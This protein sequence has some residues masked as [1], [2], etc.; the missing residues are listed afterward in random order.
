MNRASGRP[1]EIDFDSLPSVPPVAMRVVSLCVDPDV[2]LA[3][4]SAAVSLDP[5]LSARILRTA[6][7]A[8]FNWGAEVI[9][10]D[11]AM[12]LMGIKLV[13]LTALGL[14]ISSSL[15][16]L[17]KDDEIVGQV[18]HQCLV[19]AV[20][21]RELAQLARLPTAPESWLFG[22]FDGMGHLLAMATNGT[23]FR[24]LLRLDPFP[25]VPAQRAVLG[26]STNELV[27]TA[28]RAWGV[29]ELYARVL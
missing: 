17:P 9:S 1:T 28:L 19:R 4:L 25:D 21:C 26:M 23:A 13:K 8:A 15:S 20:A 6:N 5:V 12:M 16:G 2:E 11:K 29:P 7:S 27:R 18:W 24:K 10:L 22:L 3:G 14:V